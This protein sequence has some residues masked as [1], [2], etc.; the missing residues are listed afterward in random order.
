MYDARRKMYSLAQSSK[1]GQ[2]NWATTLIV[3]PSVR[4]NDT[5]SCG[6]LGQREIK[7]TCSYLKT[8][9]ARP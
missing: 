1:G 3:T 9:G 7:E 2:V 6:K 8:F 5:A 4:E